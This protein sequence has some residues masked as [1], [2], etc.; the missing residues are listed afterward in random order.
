MIA[1]E[2]SRLLGE[3][4]LSISHIAAGVGL[5]I[6]TL[7]MA[8]PVFNAISMVPFTAQLT[9]LL[10]IILLPVAYS[11]LAYG[12]WTMKKW[13]WWLS[14]ILHT[15]ILLLSLL[16]TTQINRVYS[17][18]LA[19]GLP[20]NIL[21][22]LS[23][24]VTSVAIKFALGIVTIIYLLRR[25]GVFQS[26][27]RLNNLKRPLIAATLLLTILA[28]SSFITA[29]AVASVPPADT[30]TLEM[31]VPHEEL[32]DS[33]LAV[34]TYQ[35]RHDGV[36]P[37]MLA[38]EIKSKVGMDI[39]A[40]GG[41]IL[42]I[43]RKIIV[44]APELDT[45]QK[46]VLDKVVASHHDRDTEKRF[47]ELKEAKEKTMSMLGTSY[48]YT[49]GNIGVDAVR[50]IVPKIKDMTGLIPAVNIRDNDVVVTF[51]KKLKANQK[52]VLDDIMEEE[53]STF[54]GVDEASEPAPSPE[55]GT[56]VAYSYSHWVNAYPYRWFN[57]MR[58]TFTQYD[59]LC[60]YVI[61]WSA[62]TYN[63]GGYTSYWLKMDYRSVPISVYYFG[64]DYYP[65]YW[66][67]TLHGSR[68]NVFPGSHVVDVNY[69]ITGTQGHIF[70]KVL[71][72]QPISII[73]LFDIVSL[74]FGIII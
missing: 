36:N 44:V 72:V 70:Y 8:S 43:D 46:G 2:K 45:N 14:L 37:E 32:E 10:G 38:E 59:I 4:A 12:I 15:I 6:L 71:T 39:P 69:Y 9:L 61:L 23:T 11:I 30:F 19:R 3:R 22:V 13:A 29:S 67:R 68:G 25:R 74:I 73:S 20:A 27:I 7:K 47:K 51:E 49:Q 55:R 35:S 5:L 33:G 31:S 60:D 16:Q 34:Y 18:A 66:T 40:E 17:T 26:V 50:R 62:E 48:S 57:I 65:Y 56:I 21:E 63:T 64:R 54:I 58:V 24:A 1:T 53:G 52:A 28:S 41:G 42:V